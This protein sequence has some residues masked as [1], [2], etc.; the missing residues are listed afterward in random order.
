MKANIP[1]PWQALPPAQRKSI[2]DYC[3]RVARE[4][5]IE[6]TQKDARIMLDL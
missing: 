5:A 4:A 2:E 6:A 3:K 1:R